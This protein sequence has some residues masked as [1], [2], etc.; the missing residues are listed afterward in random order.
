MHTELARLREDLPHGEGLSLHIGVNSG[1]AIARVQGS[2]VRLDYNVLG[3]A[4][5]LAQ[6]LESAAP[7][8]EIYV[9]ED[10]SGSWT[11]DSSSS[12]RS[13][14]PEVTISLLW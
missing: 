14:P 2:D 1:H 12:D 11:S 9:S 13:P 8:G 10:T 7:S 5:N 6:R 4:V 3:D